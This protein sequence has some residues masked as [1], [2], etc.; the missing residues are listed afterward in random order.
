MSL[1]EENNELKSLII[2][3]K[4]KVRAAQIMALRSVNKELI[5]LYFD[6]GKS[7]VL[8]QEEHGWG[9]AV[10]A[11]LAQELQLE[12]QGSKGF[13]LANLWRMRGFY[14]TYNQNEK[15]AQAVRE[16]GW[17]HNLLIIQRCEDNLEREY[18]IQMTRR[19]AWSRETLSNAIANGSY[20]AFL[21]SQTNFDTSLPESRIKDARLAVKDEFIFNFLDLEDDHLEKELER[22][23]VNNIRKFLTE[24]G[25]YFTFVG[26]QFCLE[27]DNKEYFI[28]LVLYHRKLRCLIAIELKQKEFQPE[29]AGKMQFYLSALDDLVRLE[30]EEPSIGIIICKEKSRTTVEYTLRHVNKPVGV[31]TYKTSKTLPKEI[32]DLLP[33]PE[34]IAQHLRV[35]E[36]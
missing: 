30:N 23:L 17:S 22:G 10:V 20:R 29:Y 34:E 11:K 32:K 33:S 2:E 1:I 15:L 25:N 28:D 26:S 21:M 35:F 19:N 9:K 5:A 16:I 8:K 4:A 14:L 3:I 31:A 24:M 12:F 18:Y 27:V 7:I 36:E 6:I 13:S